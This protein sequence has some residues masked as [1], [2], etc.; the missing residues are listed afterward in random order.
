M[1]KCDEP[2]YK[3]FDELPPIKLRNVINDIDEVMMFLCDKANDL[4]EMIDDAIITES[5]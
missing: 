1:N 4:Q 2:F 3:W 5:Q